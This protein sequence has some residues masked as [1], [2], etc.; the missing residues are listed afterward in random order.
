MVHQHYGTQT[1]NRGAVMPGMLV[2]RKDGTWTASANL[3]GRLYLHRGI[4]R[5]YV[6]N[7]AIVIHTQRLKSD[8]GGNLLS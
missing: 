4:E 5:T 2:K 6:T 1:V 8:P 7:G 3:R